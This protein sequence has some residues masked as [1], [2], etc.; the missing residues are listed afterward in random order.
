MNASRPR[1]LAAHAGELAALEPAH[2]EVLAK[3]AEVGREQVRR[4]VSGVR[5]VD[6]IARHVGG[7]DHVAVRPRQSAVDAQ[8][9]R[10]IP[11]QAADRV[12]PRVDQLVLVGDEVGPARVRGRAGAVLEAR[13]RE[14][15]RVAQEQDVLPDARDRVG[16]VDVGL[17]DERRPAAL[18]A[19]VAGDRI[20]HAGQQRVEGGGLIRHDERDAGRRGR[21]V[22]RYGQRSGS[23]RGHVRS[24]VGCPGRR[25]PGRCGAPSLSGRRRWKARCCRSSCCRRR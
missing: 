11:D 20:D 4:A 19:D 24:G 6:G 16:V 15:R 9:A 22:R 7:A 10:R 3:R 13:D 23:D 18:L 12:G 2:D 17:L 8:Q 21:R 1:G 25:C 14:D 5:P